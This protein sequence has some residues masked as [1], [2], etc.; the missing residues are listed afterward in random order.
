METMRPIVSRL[1]RGL[2][3]VAIAGFA[4]QFYLVGA[5]LFGVM[6]FQLHRS[7][8]YLLVLVVALLLI[9]ALTGMLGRRVIGLSVLLLVL[10]AVQALLP[11]LRPSMP[12]LAALHP[13]NA[14]ALIGV[15]AAIGRGP[16]TEPP[17]LTR[18]SAGGSASIDNALASEGWR[19]ADA[20]PPNADPQRLPG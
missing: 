16:R 10:V 12:W 15:A 13:V 1:H 17:G 18:A 5:A 11:S 9:L 20:V 8:G 14:L 4:V 6:T 2:A 3:W 19:G 7:V